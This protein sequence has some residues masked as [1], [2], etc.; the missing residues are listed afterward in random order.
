[1]LE[2]PI[3]KFP[4][5]YFASSPL[6]FGN[7]SRVRPNLL[8]FMVIMM[9]WILA[10]EHSRRLNL[11]LQQNGIKHY[12]L[13]LP[14]ATHGFDY[15][16]NGPGGQLSTYAVE[17]FLNTILHPAPKGKDE[18]VLTLYAQKDVR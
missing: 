2:A 10:Y 11:K 18:I 17:T 9:Y 15:N 6:E 3:N 8:L 5:K 16:L 14:W 4:Q 1:M 13:R 7:R 12:W